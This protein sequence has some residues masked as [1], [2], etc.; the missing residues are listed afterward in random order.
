MNLEKERAKDLII[1]YYYDGDYSSVS[2]LAEIVGF[3][4]DDEKVD[5][6]FVE[7]LITY[8]TEKKT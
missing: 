6:D 1:R 5:D 8:L 2:R 4:S 7:D 3:K